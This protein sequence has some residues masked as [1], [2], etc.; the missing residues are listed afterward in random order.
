[1]PDKREIKAPKKSAEDSYNELRYL[2]ESFKLGMCKH[3]KKLFKAQISAGLFF[4]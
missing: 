2:Y 1:M 4:I 3:S